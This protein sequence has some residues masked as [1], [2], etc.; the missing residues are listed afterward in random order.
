MKTLQSE[1]VCKILDVGEQCVRDGREV[2][3]VYVGFDQYKELQNLTDFHKLC[4]F[5]DDDLSYTGQTLHIA[6]IP[7]IEVNRTNH[8]EILE[9]K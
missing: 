6:G 8:F 9:G 7:V 3:A 5:V 4:T 2:K 1:I